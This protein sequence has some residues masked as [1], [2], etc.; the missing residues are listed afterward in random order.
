MMSV[1]S[2]VKN[3]VAYL[4]RFS[5]V[6]ICALTILIASI[7]L[8]SHHTPSAIA[9][10]PSDYE[11]RKAQVL[12]DA[13]QAFVDDPMRNV[14]TALDMQPF[15]QINKLNCSKPI[16]N[17]NGWSVEMRTGGRPFLNFDTIE[18]NGMVWIPEPCIQGSSNIS[19]SIIDNHYDDGKTVNRMWS[20]LVYLKGV[21]FPLL[22]TKQ[23]FINKD[24]ST[25]TLYLVASDTS[26]TYFQITT[27][28]QKRWN[29]EVFHKSLK[30]NTALE[31]YT[32][33]Q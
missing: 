9:S 15:D 32:P 23:V 17:P 1:N 20:I 21:E 31:K 24:G 29:V 26:L 28:Y 13:T 27:I 16:D 4:G 3:V 7:F 30:Q 10:H 12:T 6:I 22:L 8:L 25:G 18:I 19:P 11:T 5:I 33:G 14:E 2:N